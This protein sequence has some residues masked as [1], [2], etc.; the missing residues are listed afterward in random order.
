MR[1]TVIRED[2]VIG[3]NG[4]FRRVDLSEMLEGI[5]A[6]QWNENSGHV[7]YDDYQ[8]PN[9]MIDTIE[10]VQ[11][12]ITLWEQAAPPPPSAAERISAAHA[13]INAAYE[14]AVKELTAGYPDREIASWDKQ[15]AEARA[16]YADTSAVTPW[17]DGAAA[18]RGMPRLNLA[19]LIISNANALLPFHGALTGKRQKLRDA[20]DALGSEATQQQLDAIKW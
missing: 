16:L 15:E 2:G 13:R 11:S 1:V 18:A 6:I 9:L 3:I 7:E 10:A 19:I 14:K 5:R 12:F 4:V 20:I 8:I 17:I